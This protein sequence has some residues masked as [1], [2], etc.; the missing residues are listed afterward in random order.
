M[1]L[2][3]SVAALAIALVSATLGPRAVADTRVVQGVESAEEVVT[4]WRDAGPAMW[5][6]KDAELD[7]RF[8]D[9]FASLY[10]AAARGDL[11][12]WLDSAPS[13]LALVLLLDQY[14][15]NS[16]RGTPQ[17]YATDAM[18]RRAAD[19]AIAKGHDVH[20][21]RALRAFMYLPFGHSEQ[22]A[23]QERSVEL[24]RSLGEPELSHA[25]GHRDIIRRFGRFPHRNPILG[26]AMR[27]EE[28]QYLD[29]GGF[30]G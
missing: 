25:L 29:G 16:F 24:V 26:R 8:R 18:A 27:P 21:E 13:A 6:A 15:R 3:S 14:P 30:A 12:H 4:F 1:T 2:R 23:D 17:M 11:E 22:L 28:Q 9:R 7:R 5:F 19:I 10:V 20:V